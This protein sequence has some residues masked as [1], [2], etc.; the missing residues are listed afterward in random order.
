MGWFFGNKQKLVP[1]VAFPQGKPF[2]EKELTFPQTFSREQIIQPSA[3]KNAVGMDFP[4]EKDTPPLSIKSNVSNVIPSYASSGTESAEIF[5]KVEVYQ[6]VLGEVD[7]LRKELNDLGSIQKKIE[8]TE[9][10]EEED[11]ASM[12]R[13]LKSVHDALLRMDK[14]LFPG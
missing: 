7:G 11:F 3:V 10:H 2:D 9:Y 13:S 6:R 5:V 14:K 1:K 4:E 8:S 12:E